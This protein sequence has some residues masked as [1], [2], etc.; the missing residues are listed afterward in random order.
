[1]RV[2]D[3]G[4]PMRWFF[5]FLFVAAS[6]LLPLNADAGLYEG[7]GNVIER[8]DMGEI[9]WTTNT[10]RALGR[11]APSP[12]AKS[13]ASARLTA[14]RA[15]KVD[16]L[17]N[18]LEAV[19]GVRIDSETTVSNASVSSDVIKTRVKGVVKAAM[20][21]EVRELPDGSA[22][23]VLEAPISGILAETVYG[24]I[25]D[26]GASIPKRPDVTAENTGLVIDAKGIGAR[27]AMSP[28]IVDEDGREVYGSRFVSKEAAV[29]QGMAGYERDLN[30][31]MESARVRANPLLIK[32]VKT[33]GKRGSEIVIRN[34]DSKGLR[35]AS[36][37]LSFLEET[38]VIIV[39]E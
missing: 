5:A 10:V 9:N 37:N 26:L 27:P 38:K 1:M 11:G 3:R 21:V 14:K 30:I 22:E 12:K 2:S 23:V 20:V 4:F 13:P 32:A 8:V 25:P 7:N 18:L 33:V 36:K 35:D 19:G 34:E 17:R 31:A 6:A 29:R 24:G 16:A 28:K 39:V 15:A